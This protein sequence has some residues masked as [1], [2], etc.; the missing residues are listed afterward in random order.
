MKT[1]IVFSPKNQKS[2]YTVYQ[3]YLQKS[4]NFKFC[5]KFSEYIILNG[6]LD[7]HMFFILKG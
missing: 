5:K 2:F 7:L 3:I 1:E 6:F 4:I